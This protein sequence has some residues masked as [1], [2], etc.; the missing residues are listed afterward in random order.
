MSRP[1]SKPQESTP[2]EAHLAL[3]QLPKIVVNLGADLPT[4]CSHLLSTKL[5]GAAHIST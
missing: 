1:N 5:P 3:P 2:D 4:A